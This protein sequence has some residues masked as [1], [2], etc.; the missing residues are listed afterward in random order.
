DHHR[1][2]TRPRRL[3]RCAAGAD[4]GQGHPPQSRRGTVR[5]AARLVHGQVPVRGRD[6]R[7]LLGRRRTGAR[8]VDDRARGA[9]AGR[10][11]RTPG[12][13]A[14]R[15]PA[16]ARL[17]PPVAEPAGRLPVRRPDAQL[18]LALQ[19]RAPAAPRV[20]RHPEQPGVLQL[21]VP[22]HRHP[23]R[24]PAQQLP[25]GALPQRGRRHGPQRA[26]ADQP[27]GDQAGRRPP[28]PAGVPGLRGAAAGRDRVHRGHPRPVPALGVGAADAVDRGADALPDRAAGALRPEHPDQPERAG[29]HPHRVRRPVRQVGDQRQ[30]PAHRAPL[31]PGRADGP[32]AE[33]AHADRRPGGDGRAVVLV[34]LPGRDDRE[35]ALPGRRRDLHDPL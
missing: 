35:A 1:R 5:Q 11:V 14:A 19:V 32:G 15:V 33:A 9:G 30:R 16:R 7:G 20:P 10:A 2:G 28:H 23:A 8:V 4:P 27:H 24:L 22:G 25:P 29:Q 6:H 21:P 31:P 18:V 13:T 34:V 12:R 17:P 3:D 26:R